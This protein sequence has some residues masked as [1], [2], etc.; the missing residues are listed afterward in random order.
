MCYSSIE[1]SHKNENSKIKNKIRAN[2]AATDSV[3]NAIIS[4]GGF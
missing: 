3:F 1:D 2:L 4:A